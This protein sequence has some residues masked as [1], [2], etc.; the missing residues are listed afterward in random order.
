L[1][2]QWHGPSPQQQHF[3]CIADAV[4]LLQK[5]WVRDPA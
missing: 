3:P 5:C 4:L 1:Q 2:R